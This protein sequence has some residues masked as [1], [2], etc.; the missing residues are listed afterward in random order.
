MIAPADQ[1]PSSWTKSTGALVSAPKTAFLKDTVCR[2]DQRT[3][4][5]QP[6]IPSVRVMEALKQLVDIVMHLKS[7]MGGW[8]VDLEQT[9]ENLVT[10]VGEEI[11]ELLDA[12]DQEQNPAR[13]QA[14]SGAAALTLVSI[15][16]L[17]PHVLW[18]LASSNYEVMRLLEGV[19]SRIYTTDTQ[20]T[21]GVVRLVP[22]LSLTLTDQVY[23]LDLVTQ[24]EPDHALFLEASQRVKL[25]EN[26]LD[27]QPMA[28]APMVDHLNQEIS[29]TK[30]P[31][32]RLLQSGWPTRALSP[33]Q[34]WEDGHLQLCLHL[35]NT[36]ERPSNLGKKSVTAGQGAVSAPSSATGPTQEQTTSM[37]FTLDD[38]AEVLED[39]SQATS[40][41]VLGDWLTFTDETWVQDFLN[42]CACE[43]MLQHL[44]T[45]ESMAP[46]T[47][48]R[49]LTCIDQVDATTNLIQGEQ[50]LSKHTFVHE[51]ALVADVWL[52][53]RWYFA[54]CSEQVMQ[55]MG[56]MSC[57]VLTPGRGW[58]RGY[59]YLRPVMTLTVQ[60][61]APSSGV[62]PRI[63]R[64]DLGNGRLLPTQ[65]LTLPEDTVITIVDHRDWDPA[66]TVGELITLINHDLVD[67]APAIAALSQAG[68]PIHLHRLESEQGRQSGHLTLNWGFI[69]EPTL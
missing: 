11:G 45:L 37:G 26:D 47:A 2:L 7:P 60:E 69:L 61:A 12:L 46:S 19:R 3:M 15:S 31:L 65:P 13:A 10:Y 68:T 5:C 14:E 66:L 29:Q 6:A 55:L 18:L 42:S 56:G 52:R 17:I 48:A 53:L 27:D 54:H 59:L 51:P 22:V 49:E 28:V 35:A 33:F 40:P 39:D 32:S 16:G 30:P 50:A 23:R 38:F 34:G 21:L 58:Q 24:A 1:A 44:P 41:G 36:Q 20:F 8:P 64:L 67:Y 43:I 4:A 25:I 9:P 57:R 63:W 62:E